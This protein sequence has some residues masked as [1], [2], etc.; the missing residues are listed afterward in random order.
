[1]KNIVLLKSK[2]DLYNRGKYSDVLNYLKNREIEIVGRNHT[3]ICTKE[4]NIIFKNINVNRAN[5]LI[6][7]KYDVLLYINDSFNKDN[8]KLE[9]EIKEL[10]DRCLVKLN[11]KGIDN[12]YELTKY[13]GFINENRYIIENFNIKKLKIELTKSELTKDIVKI[14]GKTYYKSFKNAC[15][16]LIN[17]IKYEINNANFNINQSQKAIDFH[18]DCIKNEFNKINENKEKLICYY[19]KL[20][21]I[22]ILE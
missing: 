8:N 22:R 16:E 10:K 20:G 5:D 17:S 13:L 11:I 1:M 7:Y 12:I 18:K 4:F 2:N 21:A 3:I 9:E 6:K 15:N 14:N 19:D